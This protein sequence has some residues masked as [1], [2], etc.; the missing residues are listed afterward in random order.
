[1]SG[2]YVDFPSLPH[3]VESYQHNISRDILA[4]ALAEAMARLNSFT[5]EK[6]ISVAG[7]E[8]LY[9]GSMTIRVG[10]GHGHKI[11]YFKSERALKR[12]IVK[13]LKI[14]KQPFIDFGIRVSYKYFDGKRWLP[15]RADEYLIR[16]FVN[17]ESLTFHIKLSRGLGRLDPQ[18]LINMILERL[19][20]A[21]TSLGVSNPLF[22]RRSQS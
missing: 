14:L 9:T 12:I 8:G 1:M 4:D 17:Q 2:I 20:V 10:I 11:L 21:T 3:H 18:D 7:K 15:V 19:K 13:A 5:S 6:A 22:I 16:L